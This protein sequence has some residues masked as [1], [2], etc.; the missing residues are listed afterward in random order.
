MNDLK[1]LVITVDGYSIDK[2]GFE[3]IEAYKGSSDSW[4][5]VVKAYKK[6]GK[7]FSS[8]SDVSML[9]LVDRI[10]NRYVTHS[11]WR[12]VVKI[13]ELIPGNFALTIKK[14]EDEKEDRSD[15]EEHVEAEELVGYGRV[16]YSCHIC[17]D[18]CSGVKPGFEVRYV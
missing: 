12:K 15:K 13:E 2:T 17:I 18:F 8:E 5:L 9:T 14:V 6:E 4:R 3:I 7:D 16:G 11:Y 10:E 1:D